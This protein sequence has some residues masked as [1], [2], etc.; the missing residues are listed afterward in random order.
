MKKKMSFSTDNI[1]VHWIQEEKISIRVKSIVINLSN[2]PLITGTALPYIHPWQSA[3]LYQ[4]DL[5]PENAVLITVKKQQSIV[6]NCIRHWKK[7]QTIDPTFPPGTP[8]FMSTQECAGVTTLNPR[9]IGSENYA[10]GE[11]QKMEIRLN[12]W[13]APLHTNCGIHRHHD[14]MELHTQVYGTGYMQAFQEPDENMLCLSRTLVPGNTHEPWFHYNENTREWKYPWHCYLSETDCVW[15][16][17]EL[18]RID[19]ISI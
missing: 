2:H 4:G 10:T 1:D 16:A 9:Y 5:Y 3:V 14:F 18:H 7:Y 8:L 17:I 15:M 13:Y 12:L 6:A 19:D 11:T